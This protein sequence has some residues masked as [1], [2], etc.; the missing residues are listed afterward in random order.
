MTE[1][2]QYLVLIFE[3]EKPINCIESLLGVVDMNMVQN[4]I[5]IQRQ[6]H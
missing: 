1:T 2:E 4:Y 5:K 6:L 3:E